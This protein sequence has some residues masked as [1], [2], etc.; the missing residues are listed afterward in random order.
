MPAGAPEGDRRAVSP[1]RVRRFLDQW[2]RSGVVDAAYANLI[3]DGS[4]FV[5]SSGARCGCCYCHGVF[6][7]CVLTCI[8]GGDSAL[9]KPRI[10]DN[11][12]GGAH[13][14][15]WLL[16]LHARPTIARFNVRSIAE[17]A[18]TPARRLAMEEAL[19]QYLL[20]AYETWRAAHVAHHA[21]VQLLASIEASLRGEVSQVSQV[22]DVCVHVLRRV[23]F[24]QLS[25]KLLEVGQLVTE[26]TALIDEC[27]SDE[28]T[29][30]KWISACL[31]EQKSYQSAIIKC[32][33]R[34]FQ[35]EVC[36][37]AVCVLCYLTGARQDLEKHFNTCVQ[38]RKEDG[39]PSMR[40]AI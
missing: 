14:T 39:C 13:L 5:R 29:V 3:K 1:V 40:D 35:F 22:V 36:R 11:D 19:E 17:L 34:N 33:M 26:K 23:R 4:H 6:L 32:D 30:D 9:I 16:S 15:Q 20:R 7:C 27:E 8:I 25:Q 2:L 10:E 12:A 21:D 38:K 28:G 24:W 18:A 37:V 31:G